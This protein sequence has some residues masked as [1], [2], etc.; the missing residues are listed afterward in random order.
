MTDAARLRI[1]LLDLDPAPW[2]EVEVPGFKQFM[3]QSRCGDK[4][5]GQASRPTRSRSAMTSAW[6]IFSKRPLLRKAANQ[7]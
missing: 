4:A 3:G 7:R 2:R 1:T 5:D 6:L